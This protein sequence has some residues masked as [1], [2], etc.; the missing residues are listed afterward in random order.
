MA[1]QDT[2]WELFLSPV[3]CFFINEE[4]LKRYYESIDWQQES[5]RFRR[6][7]VTIPAYYSS[8][9]FHGIE[10]GYLNPGAAVSYDPVTQYVLPPNETLV[11]QGLVDRI[12][13]KPRRIL[14]L[15]CGTGSTTLMLKQALTQAQVIG[16]DLSP[17][18]LVR[19]EDKA[20]K[21]GLD[22]Q[23]RHGNAEHTGFPDASFDLVTASLLF[24]ET[25]PA[26]TQAIL[27]ECFRLLTVGGEVLIL[28]GSQKTLRNLDWLNNIFEEP[29][30]RD[31][32]AGSVDA[33]MGKAGFEAV[34]TDEIWGIHQVTRGVK[35]L[36]QETGDKRQETGEDAPLGEWIPAPGY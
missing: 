22:I 36:M 31:F 35:P 32:A 10:K 16:L 1:R 34:Q 30:I 15:G 11:R 33:W 24:H 6:A 4:E 2:I 28:D 12:R 3:V 26:V 23:W 9:N 19:A 17:Y 29:Y 5:D 27:L 7:D 18:M 25:P 20:K 21:T 14:D 13:V 8:Q